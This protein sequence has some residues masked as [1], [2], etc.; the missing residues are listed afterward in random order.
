MT[1]VK[2]CGL[3]RAGEVAA[4]VGAG[5]DA[6]GFVSVQ[7]S[8]RFLPLD[9]IGQ[10]ADGVPDPV[11][12]V[13]LTLDLE[14]GELLG[15]RRPYPCRRGATVWEAPRNSG[16]SSSG[17]RLVRARAR[18]GQTTG[19]LLRAEAGGYAAFRRLGLWHLWRHRIDVRLDSARRQERGLRCG[20]RPCSRQCR[21]SHHSGSSV[22]C[23]RVEPAREFTGCQRRR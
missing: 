11:R 12:R 8:P 14:P 21:S 17:P 9:R 10:L 2:V 23:R 22:G 6:V 7:G 19:G 1:W 18:T 13:L 20:G 5:A 15:R 3:S 16:S 4:A